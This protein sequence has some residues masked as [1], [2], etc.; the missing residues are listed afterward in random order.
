MLIDSKNFWKLHG[1][2]A[3]GTGAAV[4]SAAAIYLAWFAA[5]GRWPSGG[6]AIGLAMGISA[7]AIFLFEVALVARKTTRFRTARW[8]L[9][10]QT[11]MKAHIWLGLAT[12]PLVVLHSGGQLGGTLTMWLLAVFAVVIVS[13]VWGLALQNFLPRMLLDGAPAETVYSQIEQVGRQYAGEAR[14]LVQ[15]QCGGAPE[16]LKVTE[17][18]L[19]IAAVGAGHSNHSDHEI[20]G[21]PRRVGAQVKRSPHPARDLPQA[22]PAPAVQEALVRTIEP[23]LATGVSTQGLLGSR[24]RNQWFFDDLR[25]RVVPELRDLVGQLEELCERRRQLNMQRQVHWWL[26]NWLW[27]HLPL[28]LALLVLLVGHVIFALQFG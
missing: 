25:L 8:A 4:A 27:W 28:S 13:G 3:V 5:T 18:D 10:A 20:R 21:A 24:P 17:S 14:R 6:S 2:W 23:Y 15:L 7:G 19:E 16:V 12:V 26:H 1:R 22:L 9:S 11:W